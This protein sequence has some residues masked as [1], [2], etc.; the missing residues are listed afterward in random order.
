MGPY[1]LLAISNLSSK[2]T[3]IVCEKVTGEAVAAI[4]SHYDKLA[5]KQPI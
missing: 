3:K 4:R 2:T 1:W 5:D